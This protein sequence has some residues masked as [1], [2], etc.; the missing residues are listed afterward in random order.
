MVDIPMKS[1]QPIGLGGLDCLNRITN[2]SLRDRELRCNG[3]TQ[4]N[5][6]QGQC[7]SSSTVQ[8][9]KI[10]QPDSGMKHIKK[11]QKIAIS[12]IDNIDV[13]LRWDTD[14]SVY[15]LDAEC[16]MVDKQD[17][18]IGDDWFVFYGSLES[19]DK[20]VIHNGDTGTEEIISIQL[21]K[22]D[23]RVQKLVFVLTIN[24]ALE[25]GLNF[26][27]VSN[28]QVIIKDKRNGKSL[29]GFTLTDYY[30]TVTSMVVGEI[31]RYNNEWKFNA[32]GNG[33]AADLL[34]LCQ[35]YGVNA[36]N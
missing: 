18:V 11:G 20:S 6:R 19:P 15:G 26:S 9:N 13:I 22:V 10:E 16:F 3:G 27:G 29:L 24:E 35:R 23:S 34:G 14:R 8:R 21:S 28:A 25:M 2:S 12:G 7:Y 1:A 4:S 32:V 31:Y 30:D 17:R 36:E 33:V 5:T